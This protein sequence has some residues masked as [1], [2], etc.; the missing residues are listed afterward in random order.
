[1]SSKMATWRDISDFD[2]A[3]AE[4]TDERLAQAARLWGMQG[5]TYKNR[6]EQIGVLE[7]RATGDPIAARFVWEYL[8]P[9]ERTVLFRLL[10]PSARLGLSRPDLMKKTRLPAAEVNEAVK[11]LK[12]YV[13]IYEDEDYRNPEEFVLSSFTDSTDVLYDTGREFFKA[14]HDRSKK[15]FDEVI[16]KL[17]DYTIYAIFQ[18]YDIR[19]QQGYYP[20]ASLG[21]LV[22]TTL[23]NVSE[24]L[25]FLRQINEQTKRVYLWLRQQGGKMPMQDVRTHLELKDAAL[26]EV[27]HDLE[28]LALAF[29]TFSGQERVLFIPQ[30]IYSRLNSVVNTGKAQA[31]ESGQETLDSDPPT[32]R[33]AEP[34]VLYDLAVLVNA[35]H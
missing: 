5:K 18:N 12:N 28:R 25:D 14:D 20:Q 7:G 31:P 8:S 32:V 33:H 6:Q 1:M 29:D 30:D 16:A 21:R 17:D 4:C 22:S 26:W 34:V 27:L 13:L 3:L 15:K 35:I 9:N 10:S 2:T 24:P 23:I 11:Q 19:W